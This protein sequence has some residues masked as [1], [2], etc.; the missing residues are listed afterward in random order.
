MQHL[1]AIRDRLLRLSIGVVYTWFGILKCYP[2]FSPTEM[3]VSGTLD[4]LT[5][6]LLPH[7]IPYTILAGWELLIGVAFLLNRPRKWILYLAFL[8][9][10]FSFTPLFLQPESCFQHQGLTLTL[11]GQYFMKNLILFSA[12]LFVLPTPSGKRDT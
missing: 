3:L 1:L 8:H 10:L 2:G 12:L 9:I 4:S 6:G 11:T 5:L 7:P